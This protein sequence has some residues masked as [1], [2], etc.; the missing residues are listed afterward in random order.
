MGVRQG[1]RRPSVSAAVRAELGALPAEVS[2]S[3]A[4]VSALGIAHS[5]DSLDASVLFRFQA[6]LVRELRECMAELRA[7]AGV[8][9]AEETSEVPDAVADLTSRIASRR[10]SPSG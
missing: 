1:P 4:A 3:S 2:G 10:G 7:R 8:V 9:G 5:L 6:G